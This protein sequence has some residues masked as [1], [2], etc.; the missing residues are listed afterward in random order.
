MKK[1]MAVFFAVALVVT[2][3]GTPS[4]VKADDCKGKSCTVVETPQCGEV[5]PSGL[6][7]CSREITI[8]QS[9]QKGHLGQGYWSGRK[10]FTTTQ[11]SAPKPTGYLPQP[12]HKRDC[13]R[14]LTCQIFSGNGKGQ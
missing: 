4:S 5:G 3:V 10:S 6:R 2:L 13:V 1:L 8:S 7:L 9:G 14:T 12:F 11:I